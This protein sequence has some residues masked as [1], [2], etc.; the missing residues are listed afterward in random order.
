MAKCLACQ[1]RL[2]EYI[3]NLEDSLVSLAELEVRSKDY[4]KVHKRVE[5][6]I[7]KAKKRKVQKSID[8]IEN[9]E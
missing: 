5:R 1:E 6:I 9:E 8:H 7:T 4:E 3:V 2:D